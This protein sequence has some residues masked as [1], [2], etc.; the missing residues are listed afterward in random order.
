MPGNEILLHRF[1]RRKSFLGAE[2][3]EAIS[4]ALKNNANEFYYSIEDILTYLD[5][6]SLNSDNEKEKEA[7]THKKK[8][9]DLA[10]REQ[11]SE[12][13]VLSTFVGA[14]L[15]IISESTKF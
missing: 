8:V 7:T 3:K 12:I 11:D 2:K 13:C 1:A 10:V 4:M 6:K 14:K 5:I 15:H 9:P